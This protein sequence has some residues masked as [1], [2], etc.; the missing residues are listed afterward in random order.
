MRNGMTTTQPTPHHRLCFVLTSKNLTPPSNSGKTRRRLA[1][2]LVG[3]QVC[4]LG[5]GWGGV[6]CN[7]GF[8]CPPN[9]PTACPIVPRGVHIA[10][11]VRRPSA[12]DRQEEPDDAHGDALG[13]PQRQ[14]PRPDGPVHDHCRVLVRG[15]RV[16]VVSTRLPR[17][18]C[19]LLP[20]TITSPVASSCTHQPPSLPPILLPSLPSAPP[21]QCLRA[22]ATGCHVVSAGLLGVRRF[23]AC[24]LAVATNRYSV[25]RA[26]H[27]YTSAVGAVNR[28]LNIPSPPPSSLLPPS[29]P[30]FPPKKNLRASVCAD[31]FGSDDRHV[32]QCELS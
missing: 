7:T 29:L 13:A 10:V 31:M 1:R 4:R 9:P 25:R 20:G 30:P 12:H 18:R 19:L 22:R 28:N 24:P 3:R 16:R 2:R 15:D 21:S 6:V 8:G 11:L 23:L 26:R 32:P 14:E 5:V 17:G 27:Y